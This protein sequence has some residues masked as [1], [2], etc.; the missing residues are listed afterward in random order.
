[1]TVPLV[2]TAGMKSR[3]LTF[4]GSEQLPPH[5]QQLSR[6]MILG[7]EIFLPSKIILPDDGI[8]LLTAVL[9]GG[10]YVHAVKNLWVQAEWAEKMFPKHCDLIALMLRAGRIAIEKGR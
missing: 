2:P 10:R 8:M 4:Q 6:V 1:M 5:L 7:E 3:I 9:H